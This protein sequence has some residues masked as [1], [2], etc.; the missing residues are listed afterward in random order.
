MSRKM[1]LSGLI[2]A[3]ITPFKP[4]YSIDEES[5]KRHLNYLASVEG[6]SGVC[7]N[8]H[9]GEVISLSRE[10]RRRVVEVAA[11]VLKG[12][13]YVV[14]G[15]EAYSTTQAV[16]LAEDAKDAG[17]DLLLVFPPFDN[18]FRRG[19]VATSEAPLQYFKALNE[20]IDIPLIVF[21]YPLWSCS[22]SLETLEQLVELEHVVAVK[23][24]VW[25][26][27]HYK[28]HYE[29]LKDKVSILIA[30]DGYNLLSMLMI[31]A[32]GALIGVS[33][34]GTELFSKLIRL[35]SEGRLVE[36]RGLMNEKLCWILHDI[37]GEL[38]TPYS[39]IARIKEAL[40]RL[41]RIDYPT[42]R[43]PELQLPDSERER[44]R[45]ALVNAGLISQ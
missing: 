35:V 38:D 25:D 40:Y 13:V 16:K 17:A 14:A 28:Q 33:N 36:A 30:N 19:F 2:P 29:R 23:D 34:V 26:V 24:A 11:E 42:V 18:V 15:L 44:V 37:F 1:R 43:P 31:G 10:E 45:R 12:R 20:A 7:V 21:E 8:G 9:L 6:V 4:D 32:D 39:P 22:Y 3:S 27:D 41:G 5:F